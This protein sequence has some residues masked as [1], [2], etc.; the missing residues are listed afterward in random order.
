MK[1]PGKTFIINLIVYLLLILGTV[2]LYSPLGFGDD[3]EARSSISFVYQ[4]F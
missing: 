1:K 4:Q 3:K 2:I